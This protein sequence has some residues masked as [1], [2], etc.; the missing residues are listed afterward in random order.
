MR[1]ID[2]TMRVLINRRCRK[3]SDFTSSGPTTKKKGVKAMN[4]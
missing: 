3:K 1:R 4:Q 2:M